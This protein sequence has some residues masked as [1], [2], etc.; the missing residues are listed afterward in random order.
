MTCLIFSNHFELDNS[1]TVIDG[2]ILNHIQVKPRLMRD[3]RYPYAGTDLLEI[4][5]AENCGTYNKKCFP[6]VF[7]RQKTT[8]V[9][10]IFSGYPKIGQMIDRSPGIDLVL[11]AH[12]FAV[13]TG[14]IGFQEQM[15]SVHDNVQVHAISVT[16]QS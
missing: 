5:L 3:R 2:M 16:Y 13:L 7:P 4:F 14:V 15:S 6:I 12:N 1:L 11:N 8:V 10:I 9:G